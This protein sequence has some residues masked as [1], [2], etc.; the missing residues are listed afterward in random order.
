MHR[1]LFIDE[2]D[3]VVA[4]LIKAEFNIDEERYVAIAPVD[5][6]G[7]KTYIY[8]IEVDPYGSESITMPERSELYDA[9][10]AYEK[11]KNDALQW[12]V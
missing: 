6:P 4:F 5:D 8:K 12:G 9:F 2:Y 7:S 1:Q 10:K 3:N 11:V